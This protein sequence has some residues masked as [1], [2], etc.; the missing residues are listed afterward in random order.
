MRGNLIL[1]C[2]LLMFLFVFFSIMLANAQSAQEAKG[3]GYRHPFL[4]VKPGKT[5][6]RSIDTKKVKSISSCVALPALPVFSSLCFNF[7]FER[8]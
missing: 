8:G 5:L 4:S 6:N 7:K 2:F 3:Y 1:S